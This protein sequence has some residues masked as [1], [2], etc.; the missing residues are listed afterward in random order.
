MANRRSESPSAAATRDGCPTAFGSFPPVTAGFPASG[1]LPRLLGNRAEA[2]TFGHRPSPLSPA[3][4]VSRP[5]SPG[6]DCLPW[7]RESSLAFSLTEDTRVAE[8]T[9]ESH[10][11][12][13]K[14][15]GWRGRAVRAT[16]TGTAGGAQSKQAAS[17][18]GAG[19]PETA[20]TVE[21]GQ[22]EK[23]EEETRGSGHLWT[24]S[25][26]HDG[27]VQRRGN[28][29]G[30][31]APVG[32]SLRDALEREITRD[33]DRMETRT[34]EDKL[35]K[36]LAPAGREEEPRWNK[37]LGESPVVTD[38]HGVGDLCEAEEATGRDGL[39]LDSI[40]CGHDT[41]SIDDIR[42]LLVR[43]QMD[44]SVA[45]KVVYNLK[46]RESV[47]EHMVGYL[48]FL[49]ER[50]VEGRREVDPMKESDFEAFASAAGSVPPANEDGREEA[51]ELCSHQEDEDEHD[52]DEQDED[53]QD[54]DEQDEDEQDEDEHDEDEH[55]EDEHDEDE[56]D[57][58]EDTE[59]KDNGDLTSTHVSFSSVPK[60]FPES[61]RQPETQEQA[62]H[63]S[64]ASSPSS[65]SRSCVSPSS[66]SSPCPVSPWSPSCLRRHAAGGEEAQ[67]GRDGLGVSATA[68]P[69]S[70]GETEER[71]NGAASPR[72][73]AKQKEEK[74]A[75]PGLERKQRESRKKDKDEAGGRQRGAAARVS[76]AEWER[77]L[78]SHRE[79]VEFLTQL[80][81]HV[82]ALLLGKKRGSSGDRDAERGEELGKE[83][84]DI[85]TQKS[86]DP[87]SDISGDLVE[88]LRTSCLDHQAALSDLVY[89]AERIRVKGEERGTVA[90][91]DEAGDGD[92]RKD[93]RETGGTEKRENEDEGATEKDRRRQIRPQTPEETPE[94]TAASLCNGS[95]FRERPTKRGSVSPAQPHNSSGASGPS[96]GASASCP[97]SPPAAPASSSS[98]VPAPPGHVL[99]ASPSQP[100]LVGPAGLQRHSGPPRSPSLSFLPPPPAD[101]SRLTS[102]QAVAFSSFGPPEPRLGTRRVPPPPPFPPPQTVSFSPAPHARGCAY[103]SPIRAAWAGS[104]PALAIS[105]RPQR[106]QR[107]PSPPVGSGPRAYSPRA[108]FPPPP[109]SPPQ[110]PPRPT[111]A[112]PHAPWSRGASDGAGPPGG[113]SHSKSPQEVPAPPCFPP[114]ISPPRGG[115][116]G[117]RG[118]DAGDT[119][120]VPASGPVPSSGPAARP[121]PLSAA[122]PFPSSSPAPPLPSADGGCV[123]PP[124]PQVGLFG[125]L[126]SPPRLATSP[127][128]RSQAQVG[129]EGGTVRRERAP[130]NA[131]RKG[132]TCRGR[133][134]EERGPKGGAL[135]AG[136]SFTARPSPTPEVRN[137]FSA[138]V[139]H[140]EASSSFSTSMAALTSR[141][142]ALSLFSSGGALASSSVSASP[143]RGNSAPADERS[144]VVDQEKLYLLLL[145]LRSQGGQEGGSREG[146]SRQDTRARER[147]APRS[148]TNLAASVFSS[149]RAPRPGTGE[150]EEGGRRNT[151]LGFADPACP[152]VSALSACSPQKTGKHGL[153]HARDSAEGRGERGRGDVFTGTCDEG[154]AGEREEKSLRHCLA[155]DVFPG[156]QRLHTE[157]ER[158]GRNLNSDGKGERVRDASV[159]SLPA[160]MQVAG[161]AARLRGN[162]SEAHRNGLSLGMG[163]ASGVRHPSADDE[164]LRCSGV[165]VQ[166]NHPQVVTRPRT[167]SDSLVTSQVFQNV[168]TPASPLGD[169]WPSHTR[170]V[171]S[172]LPP[173]AHRSGALSAR[174]L[175]DRFAPPPP[176]PP[177]PTASPASLSTSLSLS[178]SAG[179]MGC[180]RASAA[181]LPP[182]VA[183]LSFSGD[184]VDLE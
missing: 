172:S 162:F 33:A 98:R 82:K 117:R 86:R 105:P 34:P 94:E 64:Y 13:E 73:T 159:Y 38:E 85:G 184:G 97:S 147:A 170:S 61:F 111:P 171:R 78:H 150:A 92:R 152:S 156:K 108:G 164:G 31:L 148:V 175:E 168:F 90:P 135:R 39:R 138:S 182:S 27:H 77:A 89:A 47:I 154:R 53:E 17:R 155:A 126:S 169:A 116:H 128:L 46:A 176:P 88:L 136:T 76:I 63:V 163:T 109:P 102:G 74:I 120:P 107:P 114:G 121:S 11:A 6:E 55:D 129:S 3:A 71:V 72:K 145:L 30:N 62:A 4:S 52:E 110:P 40:L 44:P 70:E 45:Q 26:T 144:P 140:A 113:A 81:Q 137:G 43:S 146:E 5:S 28:E 20:E 165:S 24:L 93:R 12:V 1:E 127:R 139:N 80:M 103:S 68:T 178:S 25:S 132:D 100:A 104:T 183:S 112:S 10:G 179:M 106:P 133:R 66:S 181:G 67:E 37:A 15:K 149:H 167:A 16:K 174:L 161:L 7:R 69:P 50:A 48:A 83:N 134:E 56:H 131:S 32:Q 115:A 95:L 122:P 130:G 79:K 36:T 142:S 8:E 119:G 101:S 91:G 29:D 87:T 177:P 49:L 23:R 158:K 141:A 54:E 42:M 75:E 125:R 151:S 84:P 99:A 41:A 123:R 143:T 118:S 22:G 2:P 9:P 173:G 59:E 60:H 21:G 58:D 57:E 166:S 14:G 18:A 96:A 160:H 157:N 51:A 124:P 65:A 35:F 153:L 19:T 180:L